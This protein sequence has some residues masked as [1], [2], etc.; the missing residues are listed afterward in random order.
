MLSAG[1]LGVEI[2][3]GAGNPLGIVQRLVEDIW[4]GFKPDGEVIATDSLDIE[5]LPPGRYRILP[6]E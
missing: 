2:D 6:I 1:D 4:E 3:Y 5:R